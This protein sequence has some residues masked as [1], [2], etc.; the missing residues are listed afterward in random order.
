MMLKNPTYNLMETGAVISKGLYRYEQF[1]K[2]AGECQQCQK[3][4]QSMKQQDEEQLHQLL[5][6]MKQHIDKEMKSV[7]VA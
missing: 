1:R 2:D 5:V 3:L 6:H 7:A 4:W